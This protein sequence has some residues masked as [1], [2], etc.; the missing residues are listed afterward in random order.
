MGSNTKKALFVTVTGVVLFAVLMNFS[1]VTV[2]AKKL[3]TLI[4]PVVVGAIIALFLIVPMNGIQKILSRMFS[5][6]RKKP[7]EKA[8]TA[9]SFI[10]TLI[11]VALVLTLVLTL[12]IPEITSSVKVLYTQ[13][14]ARI[15]E[16]SLKHFDIQW[17]QDLVSKINFKAILDNFS[18]IA[19]KLTTGADFIFVN[20][21]SV[22]SST[23]NIVT[24]ALFAIIIA[25]YAALEKQ[26]VA[27]HGK[28]LIGA[29]LKPSWAKGILRFCRSFS[30]IFSKFL[31]GQCSEALILGVLIFVTFSI[32]KMPYASLV[33]V[34]T[35]V[36][37][38]IPYIGAF[39]SCAI[40]VFLT[41]LVAPDKALLCLIIYLA[42][43]FIET[44]LIYPRVV[45]TAVG[46]SPLY[47]LVAALIGG[48]LLGIV[49]IIFFIPLFAVILELFNENATERI[50]KKVAAGDLPADDFADLQDEEE[51]TPPT[52]KKE[53]PQKEP[54]AKK[55]PKVKKEK[56]KNPIEPRE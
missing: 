33:S 3:I 12:L 55:P 9:V 50:A 42:V 47:T 11:C 41:L 14:E 37:A 34:L 43:Q 22:F 19:N 32:F 53:R 44:Q 26:T 38:I 16:L 51:E 46:L 48:N 24:T 25:A 27:K 23:I 15:K 21:V 5:K 13:I 29:Y 6:A 36:C 28:L 35:A 20:V 39:I 17:V 56:A 49:G 10:F 2:Y 45:G 40:S 4:L 52:P 7:S 30:D 31:F 18:E 1:A 8:L 54:K